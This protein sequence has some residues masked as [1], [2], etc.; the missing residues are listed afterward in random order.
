MHAEAARARA[1]SWAFLALCACLLAISAASARA[2]SP[3]VIYQSPSPGAR[4]VRPE[5]NL[6]VRFDQPIDA[7]N[8]PAFTVEGSASGPH[9]GRTALSADRQTVIFTPDASFAWGETV[10]VSET[11]SADLSFSIAKAPVTRSLRPARAADDPLSSQSQGQ[12]IPGSALLDSAMD[13]NSSEALP[14]SF[15]PISSTIYSTPSHG[16]LFM[17]SFSGNPSN[18]SY[19]MIT[20]NSGTP[21]YYKALNGWGLDFKM[22]PNGLLTYYDASRLKFFEMDSSFSV[23]DSFMCGNGYTADEHDLRLLPNGHALLMAYDGEDVDMSEEVEGG[24]SQAEVVGCI[25]QELD[26]NKNVVF[27]WRSWDHFNIT[28]ATH[29]DLQ[30]D[31]IDYVHGNALEVDDD[32]NILLS[33]RHMDEITKI[34]RQTGDIIWRWGGKNNQ[35]NFLGDTLMFSHQHGIRHIGGDHYVL[36]DNGN[37]HNPPYS[38]AVEYVLNQQSLTARKVWEYRN[39]PDTFGSAMGYVQR[40]DDG[41]TLITWGTG[42]PN[43][44][45]VDPNGQNVMELSLPA[46]VYTYR[47]YRQDWLPATT[48]VAT[49]GRHLMLSANLP[50]PFRGRT[51]MTLRTSRPSPVSVRVFDTRGRELKDVVPQISQTAGTYH[52]QLD[53]SGQAG[54]VY[55]CQVTTVDG[56][57]SRRIVHLR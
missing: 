37:F 52:V 19:L 25:I 54:G 13:P 23:V 5:S 44:I 24:D 51:D 53:L 55:L 27:E 30:G 20:D 57:E 16:M 50:N 29:E 9:T 33:S 21:M 43:V 14:A 34:D 48:S 36:F 49:G 1:H 6:I 38:R 7:A 4:N 28:D 2:D 15:P 11:G 10:H 47:A 45:E 17:A 3:R 26:E 18:P 8:L 56:T 35:F 40:L 32:G 46:N 41:N 22:Q 31:F 42:K 12:S 39:T